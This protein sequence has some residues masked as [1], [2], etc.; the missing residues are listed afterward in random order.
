MEI[1]KI[2]ATKDHYCKDKLNQIIS[3]KIDFGI[4]PPSSVGTKLSV[5]FVLYMSVRFI[6]RRHLMD[7]FYSMCY[8][9]VLSPYWGF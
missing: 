7:S 2:I 5:S 3:F 4:K 8:L 9:V 6:L 1:Q